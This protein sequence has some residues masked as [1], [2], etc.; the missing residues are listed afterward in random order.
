MS[1]RSVNLLLAL[2]ALDVVVPLGHASP[3][4]DPYGLAKRGVDAG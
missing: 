2:V 1:R 3:R 4:F